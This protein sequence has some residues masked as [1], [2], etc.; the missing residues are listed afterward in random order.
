LTGGTEKHHAQGR[1]AFLQLTAHSLT[2]IGAA[3]SMLP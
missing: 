2:I 3:I 1:A